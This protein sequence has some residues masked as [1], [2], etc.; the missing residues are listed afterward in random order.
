[1]PGP[2]RNSEAGSSTVSGTGPVPR[3]SAGSNDRSES[4]WSPNHSMRTGMGW[5][6]AKTSRMPPRR[7]NSPRPPTSGT[8]SYP[9]STRARTAGS[10]PNRVPTT[11]RSGSAGMS[12]G[13]SVRWKSACRL[14]TRMRAGVP[15][16]RQA[17]RLATRA[18]DSSRTSSE[19]SKARAVRGSSVTTCSAL[20][21]QAPSSSATRSAISASRATHTRRSPEATASPA[22]RKVLAPWGIPA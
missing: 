13:A 17:A 14:A 10:M 19:R 21:S 3:W 12:S 6:A 8:C 2:R 11:R 1:M 22:A 20:P 9:S 16:R 5:P 15:A 4:I 7:A 18:A